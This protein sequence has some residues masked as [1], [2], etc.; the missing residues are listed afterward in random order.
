MEEGDLSPFPLQS[1]GDSKRMKVSGVGQYKDQGCFGEAGAK[2]SFAPAKG[3][4]TLEGVSTDAAVYGFDVLSPPLCITTASAGVTG[5][6][7]AY[8]LQLL[9]S[10]LGCDTAGQDP[11]A[12]SLLHLLLL[13]S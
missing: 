6:L 2:R 1:L 13:S 5:A 9:R 4:V 8:S 7:T 11:S 10:Q 12:L 3:L